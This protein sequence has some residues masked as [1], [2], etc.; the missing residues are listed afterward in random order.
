M[1]KILFVLMLISLAILGKAQTIEEGI[2]HME[3]ENF[4]MA[5]NTFNSIC[6]AD[7]KASLAYFYI[8]EVN[9]LMENYTEAEKSYKKGLSVNPQC[10]E[11]NVGLGKLQLDN[12]NVIETE[13][14][15]SSAL[16]MNKK[17]AAIPALIGDAYLNSKKP[18]AAKAVKY[19]SQ[20]RNLNL[21]PDNFSNSN[22][23]S[24]SNIH[25]HLKSVSLLPFAY[26]N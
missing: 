7:P 1:K 2:M 12:G 26:N 10:A 3:N 20:A 23:Y 25:Q 19:L 16:K 8:G 15:F 24:L 11:C 14:Y 6:K 4:A 18:D 17:S 5:L 13:K 22:Y 21:L 9:Y